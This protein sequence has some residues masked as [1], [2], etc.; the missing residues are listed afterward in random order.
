MTLKFGGSNIKSRTNDYS[1]LNVTMSKTAPTL[2][3]Q[4]QTKSYKVGQY[5]DY[6]FY[7]YELVIPLT[8]VEQKITY[9]FENQMYDFFVPAFDQP[10]NLA[11]TSCNGLSSSVSPEAV[12]NNGVT[13]LWNDIN[14]M[15]SQIY[16]HGQVGGGDQIYCD[17]V[18]SLDCLKPWLS[19]KDKIQ[20]RKD[21]FTAR[22]LDDVH[23]FYF[24][25][26]L[27]HFK[28]PGFREALA[29]IPFNFIWDDHDI[30]DGYG[31]YP[32]YLQNSKVFDGVFEA[33]LRFYLLFQHHTNVDN[34]KD[35]EIGDCS[36]TT[37]LAYGPFM[38]VLS[39]DVR[40]E[41]ALEHVVP[42]RSWNQIWAALDAL[43]TSCQ[44][45]V[46][47]ATIPL[48]YPRISGEIMFGMA[49][50]VVKST[51]SIVEDLQKLVVNKKPAHHDSI[52][53]IDHNTWADAFAKTGAF[54]QIVNKFGEPELLDDL[55]DHWYEF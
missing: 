27:E 37:L 33:A 38:A 36:Q 41:R 14:R 35:E 49:A 19:V 1:V 18:F 8:D 31:S 23:E 55:N 43:S 26:Y 40:S 24:R 50:N 15:H 52:E 32:D 39:I 22:M 11:F 42:Q 45:L 51:H 25:L 34:Y 48:C 12:K 17:A 13:P 46:V 5:K 21:P 4:F 30:F 53:E 3:S 10:Y 29:T 6:Y 2:I 44:H 9:G 20:K 28:T 16:Y 47:N 54:K 7:K